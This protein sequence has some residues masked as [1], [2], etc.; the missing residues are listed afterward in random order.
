MGALGFMTILS[1]ALSKHF[2][3]VLGGIIYS[4][5]AYFA[6]TTTNFTPLVI[7]FIAT[8]ILRKMGFDP[9]A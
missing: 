9:G 5:G 6:F 3:L 1:G 2:G 7:A 8:L 4:I